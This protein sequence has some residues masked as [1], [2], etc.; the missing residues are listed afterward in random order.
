MCTYRTNLT[1][2]LRMNVSR[3][4]IGI[5]IYILD[6]LPG[7]NYDKKVQK[8]DNRFSKSLIYLF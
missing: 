6:Y 3:G 7:V 2:E 8:Q 4:I 1:E 5:Y